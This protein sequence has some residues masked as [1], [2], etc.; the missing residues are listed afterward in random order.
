MAFRSITTLTIALAGL[1]FLA[2]TAAA[3]N[4]LPCPTSRC[5]IV[6]LERAL[7][8]GAEPIPGV[9]GVAYARDVALSLRFRSSPGTSV[10]DYQ[11]SETADFAAATWKPL[12]VNGVLQPVQHSIAGASGLKTIFVRVRAQGNPGFFGISNVRSDTVTFVERSTRVVNCADAHTAARSRGFTFTATNATSG[13][14]CRIN[15]IGD[16]LRLEASGWLWDDANCTFRLF[17]ARILRQ[18]WAIRDLRVVNTTGT[19]GF[20]SPQTIGL[21]RTVP[22]FTTT[23]RKRAWELVDSYAWCETLTL[24]GPVGEDALTAFSDANP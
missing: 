20:D 2:G 22:A 4:K 11:T 6:N 14:S 13:G 9:G 3:Q 24:E 19:T 17:G 10:S 1:C 15:N 21:S 8:A 12:R 18:H 7:I 16:R 5:P 23:E